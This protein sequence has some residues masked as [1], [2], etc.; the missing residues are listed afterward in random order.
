MK[1]ADIVAAVVK[2]PADFIDEVKVSM[3]DI[4]RQR[5]AREHEPQKL[6]REEQQMLDAMREAKAKR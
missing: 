1:L 5:A 6:T 4:D 2:V 3:A